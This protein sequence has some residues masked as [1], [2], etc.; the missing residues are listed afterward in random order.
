M[1]IQVEKELEGKSGGEGKKKLKEESLTEH[2]SQ[3]LEPRAYV[4]TD[5]I[6]F[7]NEQHC[8]NR[9][10]FDRLGELLKFQIL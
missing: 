10:W 7:T 3:T 1:P 8:T 5:E 4:L 2:L 9:R 6:V